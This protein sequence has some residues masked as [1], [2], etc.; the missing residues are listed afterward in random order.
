MRSTRPRPRRCSTGWRPAPPGPTPGPSASSTS[1]CTSTWT[2][3]S[4]SKRASRKRWPPPATSPRDWRP[5][6]RSGRPGSAAP[7]PAGPGEILDTAQLEQVYRAEAPRITA[8]LA[9]RVGD[10][11][12]AADAVQDAFV[13][14]LEHWPDGQLPPNPGGWLAT[15]ARRKAID[16]LRRARAGREKLALLAATAT[17]TYPEV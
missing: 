12:L 10:V 6:P 3:S 17:D 14:A 1:G 13:E 2:P 15:T 5:S 7:E 8:A 11:G 9:A 4:S 16:R